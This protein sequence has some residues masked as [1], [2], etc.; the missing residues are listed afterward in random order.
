MSHASSSGSDTPHEAAAPP[1]TA[2]VAA[3]VIWRR[4]LRDRLA[5]LSAG[6]SAPACGAPVLTSG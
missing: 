2:L 3:E 4:R 5:E 6:P 1:P